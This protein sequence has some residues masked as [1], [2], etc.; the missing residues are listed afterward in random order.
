VAVGLAAN[1][2]GRTD[3]PG[4]RCTEGVAMFVS[5]EFSGADYFH[6]VSTS[7]VRSF[8]TPPLL[9]AILASMYR[10]IGVLA[11]EFETMKRAASSRNLMGSNRWQRLVVGNMMGSLFIRTY[12]RG[13]RIHQ[14]ML[15]RG[16]NG[17]PPVLEARQS[18]RLDI[19]ALTFTVL[20]LV[21]GQLI[22]LG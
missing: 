8:E 7:C 20:L 1:Y 4:E 9:V 2:D 5:D 21:I 16:Y 3:D 18:G 6:P 19:L 15:S 12:E 14:A 11:E 22:Y 10:Y 17:L 13:D